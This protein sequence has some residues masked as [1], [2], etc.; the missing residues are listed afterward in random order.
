MLIAGSASNTNINFGYLGFFSTSNQ[1]LSGHTNIEEGN[2][3]DL[4]QRKIF[5]SI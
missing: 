4:G 1:Q 3:L 2:T 5:I